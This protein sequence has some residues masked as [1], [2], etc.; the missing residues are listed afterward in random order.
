MDALF[1]AILDLIPGSRN[2]SAAQH[3][4]E[5][6]SPTFSKPGLMS[7]HLSREDRLR[8]YWDINIE[9][10]RDTQMVF[11]CLICEYFVVGRTCFT[12]HTKLCLR[13]HQHS[14]DPHSHRAPAFWRWLNCGSCFS[15]EVLARR[16]DNISYVSHLLHWIRFVIGL[17]QRTV[18]RAPW[19]CAARRPCLS[20]PLSEFVLEYL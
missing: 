12:H 18:R 5:L 10:T 9:I 19:A 8:I 1:A 4:L 6:H 14:C 2:S 11:F 15:Q 3:S 13:G 16:L 20:L 7:N 17:F